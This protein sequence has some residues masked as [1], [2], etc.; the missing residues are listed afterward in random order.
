MRQ[1]LAAGLGA[2]MLAACAAN[3]PA[4]EQLAETQP[5]TEPAGITKSETRYTIMVSGTEIGAMDV[6]RYGPAITVDYEYRNNGRGPTLEEAIVL[7]EDNLPIAWS[8]SGNT[9]FGN[10]VD[11]AFA[12]SGDTATWMDSTGEGSADVS[13]PAMYITQS[14]TPYDLGIY[15]RALLADE[16]RSLPAFPAGSLTLQ[17]LESFKIPGPENPELVSTYALIGPE[18]DPT[19]FVLDADDEFFAL[20]SPEFLV[21]R[22]GYEDLD[23]TMRDLAVRYSTERF[24]QLQADTAHEF[25]APVRI[26]NVRIF[27][28]ETMALSGLSSVLVEGDT[29]TAIEP[30]EAARAEDEYVIDGE[31]GTL[32][33]GLADMHGHMGQDDAMLNIAAGVTF[34]RDMGNDNEVLSELISKIEAGTLAGPRIVKSGFIEGKSP[35]NSNN[36]II[37]TSQEEANEAVRTYCEMGDF[38]QI[39]IYNSMKGEWVPEMVDLA[40][41]CGLRVSGHVP[42][43]SRADAMIEAGY[44]E[45][46]H[47]NQVMLG[48]VLDADEDTR[49]LLRLTALMRLP[50]LDLTAAPVQHTLDLM[51]EN[52]VAIDPTYAIHEALLLGRNGEFRP[53]VEDYIDHMP[54]GVQRSAK[55]AWSKVET[56]EDDAAYRGAFDQITDV[57]AM[58]RERG[59]LI[60]FGTDMGGSF[61]LHREL[62][63]YQ[64][65]GFT[66][67]E[68]LKRATLD[69]AEYLGMGEE[70]GSIEEGK[71]AD[72]FLVPGNPVE[73]LKA[74][75][76]I[77]MVMSDGVA[78]FPSEIYPAFGIEPFT[79]A[80]A[81]LPPGE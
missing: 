17:D 65:I 41:E 57:L 37:V 81:I 27:D 63:L 79:D 47:I 7:D 56:P 3:P 80:P 55:Q 71:L 24:E 5:D 16:D 72:F 13:E 2:V 1:F 21:I 75:K 31:G 74:I 69:S 10:D 78:Y 40:H 34:V 61:N 43:F 8:I 76:T 6:L 44:D 62:E 30:G 4:G 59:I 45:M 11:E 14:G 51:V 20:I 25:D 73:D 49:T 52:G 66:P 9:T 38:F 35:F 53:G 67:G 68:I 64:N 12:I 46:T 26:T 18:L 70:I 39:K 33:P 22:E 36:G 32:V 19:Y 60:L 29:I 48:W 77:R 58:M 50:R 54:V 23:E 28:P 15:A 42:A